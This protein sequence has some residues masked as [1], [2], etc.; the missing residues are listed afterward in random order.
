MFCIKCGTKLQ[1]DAVFCYKCGNKVGEIPSATNDAPAA[2]ASATYSAPTREQVVIKTKKEFIYEQ[3]CLYMTINPMIVGF[4]PTFGPLENY[5]E[6]ANGMVYC[7]LVASTRNALGKTK[8]TRFGAVIEAV[9]ADG[10]VVFKGAGP[11]LVTPITG[12]KMLKTLLGF[13]SK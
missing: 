4:N 3:F 5:E 6:G 8:S 2:P 1:D 10:N 11:Q 7:E 12:T 13:K 9:E